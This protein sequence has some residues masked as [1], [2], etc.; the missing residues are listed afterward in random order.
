MPKEYKGYNGIIVLDEKSITI[1]RGLRGVLLGGGF[2]RGDKTIPYSS[3]VAV[4]LKKSGF[5]AGYLQLTLK[6]GSEAKAGLFQSTLDENSINFYS[7]KNKDFEEAK[8]LIE[9][10]ITND[11][12]S[13]PSKYD[14]LEKLA[15]LRESGVLSDEEFSKEKAK[16]LS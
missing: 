2:L 8:K 5:T 1:K 9:E 10:H 6:G 12:K 4:Q 16:L 3:I 11:G 13:T 7:N 14:E 15:K